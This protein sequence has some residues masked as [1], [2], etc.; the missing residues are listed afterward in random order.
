MNSDGYIRDE[1]DQERSG[2]EATR[3]KILTG[4][5]LCMRERQ[6]EVAP[7][8]GILRLGWPLPRATSAGGGLSLRRPHQSC[9]L[10]ART[11]SREIQPPALFS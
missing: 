7:T 6:P 5:G 3:K 1:I 4:G 8:R 2:L 11:R 10:H 9:A